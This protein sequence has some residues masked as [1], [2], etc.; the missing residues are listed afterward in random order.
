MGIMIA[1]IIVPPI[2]RLHRP[3]HDFRASRDGYMFLSIDVKDAD[4]TVPKLLSFCRRM[5]RIHTLTAESAF[6]AMPCRCSLPPAIARASA[7]H[8][9]FLTMLLLP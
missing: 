5:L 9:D 7:R 4:L 2:S 8:H 3:G 6:H 1:D